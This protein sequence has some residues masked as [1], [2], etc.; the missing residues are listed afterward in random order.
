MRS[1]YFTFMNIFIG[2][3]KNVEGSTFGGL[4]VFCVIEE[5]KVI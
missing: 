3:Q 4:I 2:W 1:S 5:H